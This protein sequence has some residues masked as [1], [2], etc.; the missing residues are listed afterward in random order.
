MGAYDYTIQYREGKDHAN[1][2]ALSRLPL[3]TESSEPP[4][5]AEVVHLMEHLDS[6]PE[7]RKSAINHNKSGESS[8]N[9]ERNTPFC[10]SMRSRPFVHA[11]LRNPRENHRLDLEI[12]EISYAEKPVSD[13]S[14]SASVYIRNQRYS[15]CSLR[16]FLDFDM[17]IFVGTFRFERINER[18]K[19]N[20]SVKCCLRG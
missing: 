5:P 14:A 6:S 18:Q 2:D 19:Q 16:L 3:P 7:I 20:W 1:A 11:H 17:W 15:Q 10:L 9:H 12:T 13:P 4:K 8:L